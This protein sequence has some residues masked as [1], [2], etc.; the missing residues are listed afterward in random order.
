MFNAFLDFRPLAGHIGLGGIEQVLEFVHPFVV[1]I[2]TYF[3]CEGNER[4]AW[5]FLAPGKPGA[6]PLIP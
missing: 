4:N 2:F 3:R 6:E 5:V 1:P